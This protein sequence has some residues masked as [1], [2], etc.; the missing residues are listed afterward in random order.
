MNDPVLKRIKKKEKKKRIKET[1]SRHLEELT[2]VFTHGTVYWVW[3]LIAMRDV[4]YSIQ[5]QSTT[6]KGDILI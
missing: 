6:L 3:R 5:L 1:R 4:I 2:L